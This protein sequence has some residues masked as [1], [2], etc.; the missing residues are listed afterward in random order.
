MNKWAEIDAKF[1]KIHGFDQNLEFCLQTLW[2]ECLCKHDLN[3]Y[4]LAL[5]LCKV[6]SFSVRRWC[7][8]KPFSLSGLH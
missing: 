1:F 3:F 2:R 7:S 4:R 8:L 5:N 6:L